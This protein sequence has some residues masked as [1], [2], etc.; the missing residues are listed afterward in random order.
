MIC[1]VGICVYW[2]SYPITKHRTRQWGNARLPNSLRFKARP[3]EQRPGRL[4]GVIFHVPCL[5]PPA[6][7]PKMNAIHHVWEKSHQLL[8]ELC[9]EPGSSRTYRMIADEQRRSALK[10]RLDLITLERIPV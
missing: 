2:L 10:V 8:D 6:F 9:S 1:A 4:R 7:G 3:D 5:P